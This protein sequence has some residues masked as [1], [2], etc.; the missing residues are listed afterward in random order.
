[1]SEHLL[2][3]RDALLDLA[4]Q[5]G[6]AIMDVYK[7]DFAVTAKA[8]SSPLTE[9]DL[10]AHRIISA[11][12]TKL[13]GRIPVLS[14]ESDKTEYAQ[15]K[16]WREMWLVDPLD[17]TKEFVNRNG[18][19]TVNIALVRDGRPVVGMVHAPALGRT[20]AGVTGEGAWR[21]V[22]GGW[23]PVR[24]RCYTGGP[25]LVVAS[26]SHRGAAIDAFLARLQAKEGPASLVSSGSSLKLCLVADGS[27]DVYPRLGPTSE[28]DTGAGHAV[29]EAAGGIVSDLNMQ[30]LRYNKANLLNPWFVAAGPGDY[31]W[32]SLVAG[33]RD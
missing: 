22:D 14:E 10:V 23:E 25:A 21:R 4:L 18:E 28:W 30:P 3:Y 27:A 13:P 20:Y 33:L 24:A 29:V 19:F 9:A 26:R 2:S 6:E 32:A 11:G 17:G 12:L 7:R 1:M 8:D 5:A 31:D 16:S 15:R